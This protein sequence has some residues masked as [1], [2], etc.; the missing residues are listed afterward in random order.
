MTCRGQLRH[1]GARSL[2]GALHDVNAHRL[3]TDALP[4]ASSR[5][6]RPASG[7]D[8]AAAAANCHTWALRSCFDP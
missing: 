4:L 8:D 7:G 2:S 5:M 6:A 3:V 1:V